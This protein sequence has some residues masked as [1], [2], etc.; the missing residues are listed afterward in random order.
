MHANG[1]AVS[2][3]EK[4]SR[5]FLLLKRSVPLYLLI[6]PSLILLIVFT[7]IP[8]YGVTIAFKDYKTG[9][10]IF[11]SEWVGFKNFT[12][13][14]N[15]YQFWPILRNTLVISIYSIVVMFPLPILVALIC[16]QIT[17]SRYKKFFQVTTYLPHFISTVV[18]CGMIMLFLSPSSGII[19]KLLSFVGIDMPNLMGSASAFPHIYVWTEAWQHSRTFDFEKRQVLCRVELQKRRRAAKNEMDLAGAFRKGK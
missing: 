6:L 7:Y 11:G 16:S 18:M 2:A 14:F 17:S 4:K 5:R 8:M 1:F 10:G 9:L 3:K 19:A 13:F 12:T 15:S